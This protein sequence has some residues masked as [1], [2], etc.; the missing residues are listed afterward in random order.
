MNQDKP[1]IG[2]YVCMCGSNIAGT[3]DVDQVSDAVANMNNV[4]VSRI[5]KYTCAGPGQMSIR[6]D[7]QQF[8]LNRVVVSACSPRMHERTWRS[9]LADSGLNPYLL[10]VAN[11]REH[12]SWAHPAGELTTQKAIDL[13][14]AAVERVAWHDPLFPQRVPV[15]KAALVVGAGVAGI[16]TALD[17]AQAGIHVYLVEREPSIGGHMAQL[18]KTFPTL[19]CSAC[20]LTPKMVDAGNHPNITLLSYSEVEK[21]E[22][23]IGNFTATV[24]RKAR[25]VREDACTGCNDCVEVCPVRVP[26]EFDEGLAQRTAIYRSFA[27]AVPNVFAIDKR[28]VARGGAPCKNACPAGIH[29]QGYVA[30]I[31]E[32]R[33]R[34]AYDLIRE[35]MPF[36]GACGRVCH[37]PCEAACRRGDKDTPVAI[38]Y[39][40]RAAADWVAA[41]PDVPPVPKANPKPVEIPLEG[42]RVAVVGAGPAGLTVARDLATVGATCDIYEALPVA[43]GM[44]AVGIPRY[45]LPEDILRR[46]ID[47]IVS[48]PGVKLYL[49]TP[50]Q[51]GAEGG[52]QEAGSGPSLEGLRSEYDAVFLGVGAHDSVRMRIPGEDLGSVLHGAEYLRQLSL[53][54]L[55]ADG[56]ELPAI[57][58]RVAV[59]G[60]G[61]VAIDSAMT[62]RRIGAQEVTI[63]YRRT[64]EEM[65]ANDWEIEE[66]EEEGIQFQFLATPIEV[67]GKGNLI[68]ALRCQRMRLGEPDESG[69]R[70]PVPIEGDTFDLSVDTVIMAIGQTLEAPMGDVERTRRGWIVADPVT[71]Q[72]NLPGVFAGGDA[73]S[74]PASVVEAVGQGHRVVES[75][76]RYLLGEDAALG[77]SAEPLDIAAGAS[78][79]DIDYYDPAEWDPSPRLQM[80]HRPVDERAGFD[81][82]NLGFSEA[83]A[84][85]EANRCLSCGVCSECMACVGV[86]GAGA[87]DHEMRDELIDID[88]GAIVVATGYDTWDPTPMLEYGYGVYPEV[89]TG[90]EIER[91]SNASG[92]TGGEIVKRNGEKPK[93]VAIMHCVGSRDEHYQP[94]CSRICCMYSLKLAHLI[95]E[96]T[97]A[98]VFQFY[99]DMRAFGKGYEEFYERVQREGVVMV[100][101][102][103]AQVLPADDASADGGRLIVRAEDTDLGRPINLPV[104]MVVL[105][106]AVVPS[107]GAEELAHALHV[108]RDANGFFLEGHPKLRPVDS[109]TDGIYLAGAC[110]APR[111]IPDTVAHA[112]AAASQALGLLSQEFVEVVPTVAEVR[113]LHC[114]GCGLCVEVC[115]YG[116]PSLVEN[117]GRLVAEINEA[118]CKGC[119]LCVAGCRGKAISLRGFTD[120]QILTQMEALLQ[121]EWA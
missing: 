3:V 31:A 75:I 89:Y 9:L 21:L 100:R 85:A 69:R 1:R 80:P 112:S 74:G 14:A 113:T 47:D 96:K 93:R 32:G 117:R 62:A 41:H 88:V 101:G 110:Q 12:C 59:I 94:Y 8:G 7:I 104:D 30:L 11:L 105:A 6:E 63:L 40:K 16:Q 76:R 118:L 19:D 33:F 15:T 91:L 71:L 28:G 77:R 37:H 50:V 54:Q 109:N 48:L 34:E 87:V 83:R 45:R 84:M 2:V 107:E 52:K 103:G 70:R 5:N 61:N 97:H 86:C 46:E 26:S 73:V 95:E 24:R 60:G 65:P 10:E 67:L 119:G 120:T 27:Q 17:I 20:I 92:P 44:M 25:Y 68:A 106:T 58:P 42:K 39:L 115:P 36:P 56:V 13:V 18:D 102:R 116:A 53:A 35:Q 22:G 98:E 111:D 43:G 82:V 49:N 108:T 64:R 51:L 114:V 38:E 99:M 66:A 55:G 78:K 81:E 90:L 121:L 79:S 4:V 57:G 29:V 23:Y 72:T